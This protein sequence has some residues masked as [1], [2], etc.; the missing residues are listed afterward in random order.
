MS[1]LN[2]YFLWLL[3]PLAVYFFRE[4]RKKSLQQYL[5]WVALVFLV[6]AIARPVLLESTSK[7]NLPAHS[8][9][10]AIDLSASMNADDI[11]PSRTEASRATIKEFL[12][13]NLYDQISLIGF[14]TNPLLLSPS[15]TDHKLVAL[16]LDSMK[17]EYI[18]TKG[19][20]IKKLLE[21]VAKFPDQEK[22]LILF[23][24]GGDEP[25]GETLV[26]FA[27]EKN[28][29]ILII[30]M[31]TQEGSTIIGKDD[32]V[33]K[34][35]VGHIV[36]SKFNTSLRVL[37]TVVHFDGVESTV[38][39]I[40][41]WIEEQKLLENGLTK[42]SHNYFELFFIPTFLALVLFFLSATR[43][44]LKLV[45][46]LAL[47][48][49]NVQAEELLKKE[50]WGGAHL[51]SNHLSS[52]KNKSFFDG[53]HLNS[54]YDYYKQKDY[55]STLEELGKIESKTL[56]SELTLANTYYKLKKYKEAKQV[57]KSLKSTNPKVKQQLLY[58]LGNC[59]AK[60]AYYVKAKNYYIKALQL[61][62]DNDALHNLEWVM[63]KVKEDSSKVGFTNPHSAQA[64]KSTTDNVETEERPSSKQEEKT[65]SSGGGGSKKSKTSTVKVVKSTEVSKS[66]RE[67]SSKAYDLINEGYIHDVKPW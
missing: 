28:I 52:K 32:D 19:T 24:D 63:F 8:I 58:S 11:K 42:E 40:Q 47:L 31:A 10:L 65:G 54:A 66:K 62:E 3:L 9:V 37:G 12:A 56:E 49:I 45:A 46:L 14:T 27:K 51:E 1:F 48:H 16:A 53:Y 57:L 59:E 36:V 20:S 25:I 64:S 18:L 39:Q 6:L 33:L 44:S 30:A 29:K 26:G 23:S 35:K 60:L 2:V 15:T 21:K 41:N 5:R 13:T 67:M 43:F 50:D 61:G 17:S 34:D 22:R 4:N 55:N 7:E 38:A